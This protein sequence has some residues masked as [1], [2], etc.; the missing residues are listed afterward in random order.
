MITH[1]MA[2]VKE[3]CDRVAVMENGRVV[4]EGDIVTVFA[5]PQMPVTKN[6]INTTNNLGKIDELIEANNPL[7]QINENQQIIKLQ[8]QSGNTSE[9]L[10]S[11]ISRD[12]NVTVPSY[13]EMSKL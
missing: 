3:I 1:E 11:K 13:L 9:A 10:I 2:V 6:F 8:Y 4:E 12:F 7:V 5:H